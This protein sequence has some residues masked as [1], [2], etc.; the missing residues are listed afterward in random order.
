MKRR[1]F[2]AGLGSAAAWP[3]AARAQ[4]PAMPVIGYL[5]AGSLE[6]RRE[7]VAALHHGLSET[8]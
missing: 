7:N 8:G 4:Q 3:L 5:D 6:T 2:I 1:E